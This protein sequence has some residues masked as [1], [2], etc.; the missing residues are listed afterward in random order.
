MNTNLQQNWVFAHSSGEIVKI[1]RHAMYKASLRDNAKPTGKSP[2]LEN[3]LIKY[4]V[5]TVYIKRYVLQNKN[6]TLATNMRLIHILSQ[7]SC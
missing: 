2:I 3:E 5:W 4:S 7:I 1:I 6:L